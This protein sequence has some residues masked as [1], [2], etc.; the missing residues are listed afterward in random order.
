MLYLAFILWMVILGT[1][2]IPGLKE[3]Y[4]NFSKEVKIGES[5]LVTELW[6]PFRESYHDAIEISHQYTVEKNGVKAKHDLG[7]EGFWKAMD[8][9]H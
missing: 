5:N 3:K 1:L 9:I 7:L 6:I 8:L 2:Y 4:S